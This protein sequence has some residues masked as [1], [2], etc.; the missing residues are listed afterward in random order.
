MADYEDSDEEDLG[1]PDEN[2]DHTTLKPCQQRLGISSKY[3]RDWTKANAFREF[4]QNWMDAMIQ[5]SELSREE[6][7]Y[8]RKNLTNEFRITVYNPQKKK[9]LGFLAFHRKRG[10]LELC[11]YGSDLPPEVLDMGGTSKDM[12]D[13][14]T[15]THGEGFKLAA[16]L[17]I[18]HGN[19]AKFT[20]SGFYC[21]F[22]WGKKEKKTLWCF[23]SKVKRKPS[24]QELSSLDLDASQFRVAN[25]WE[26]VSVRMGNVYG[27]KSKSISEAEQD[28]KGKVYLKGLLLEK[29][30]NSDHFRCGYDFSQGHIGRDRKGMEDPEQLGYHLA[31]IWEGAI[32]QDSSKSLDI[33]IAML[34]D[35][36]NNWWDVSNISSLMTKPMAEAIWKRLLEQDP[37]K[38]TFYHGS[39]NA[40]KDAAII[41]SSL[42]KNPVLLPDKIWKPLRKY[43]LAPTPLEYR[44]D[45]MCNTEI[46]TALPTPYYSSIMRTLSAALALDTRTKSFKLVFKKA[47]DVGL[48]LYLDMDHSQLLLHD[49][50]MD[51]E[52]SHAENSKDCI[53]SHM[54]HP[55]GDSPIE[56]FSY[57]HIIIDICSQV[58]QELDRGGAGKKSPDDQHLNSLP[59]KVGECLKNMLRAIQARPGP[60]KGE[61]C[62]SWE[63][64]EAGKLFRLHNMELKCCVT[65]H[66]ES[67]CSHKRSD[68]IAG[69]IQRPDGDFEGDSEDEMA[70]GKVCQCL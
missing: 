47:G 21:N 55:G 57:D 63:D 24:Q 41:R 42:K 16:L 22:C 62:V 17:M 5:A 40:D 60:N 10:M 11:N 45:I 12:N 36:E 31:K 14:M 54:R 23:L 68:L 69:E 7:V 49:K 50:W 13:S 28:F 8:V 35:T 33:Y 6:L 52:K 34:L 38:K 20:A 51:F 4:C 25:P 56:I 9:V 61:I 67:T 15:G 27:K 48:D 2:D 19:Q 66:Q 1:L 32:A 29:M 53:L 30:S 44:K 64:N 43:N 26:G 39:Q 3:V 18:R 70:V 65:L 58:L 46:A 37:Q 59:L